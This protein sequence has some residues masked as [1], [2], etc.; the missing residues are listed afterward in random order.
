MK[1]T[2]S[3]RLCFALLALLVPL[4]TP[5]MAASVHDEM[6]AINRSVRQL[7]RQIAD[8]AQKASSLALAA[9]IQKHATTARSLTP[10]HAQKLTGDEKARYTA[11][12]QKNLDALLKELGALKDALA[13]DKFDVAKAEL[14]KIGQLKNASHKELGVEMGPPGGGR[15]RGDAPPRPAGP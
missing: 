3:T 12:F 5:M 10:S 9:E 7:G 13:S 14:Q 8:P 15:K 6:E 1:S 2:C 11:T 4:A